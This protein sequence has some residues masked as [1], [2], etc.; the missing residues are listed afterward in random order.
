MTKIALSWAVVGGGCGAEVSFETEA[1]M[2]P[3]KVAVAETCAPAAEV[4]RKEAGSQKSQF[5]YLCVM[6]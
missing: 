1:A 3:R 2:P 4:P 5:P 6:V